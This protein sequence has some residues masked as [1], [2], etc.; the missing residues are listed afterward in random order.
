MK[1]IGRHFELLRSEGTAVRSLSSSD[2]QEGTSSDAALLHLSERLGELLREATASEEVLA[3]A[4]EG[5]NAT[6]TL[7][8]TSD[9]WNERAEIASQCA[10]VAWRHS[11]ALGK[12]K[13]A[14]AWQERFR[15]SFL[16]CQVALESCDGAARSLV[17][18]VGSSFDT[19]GLLC[20]SVWLLGV[21]NE[22]PIESAA[23]TSELLEILRTR[24]WPVLSASERRATVFAFELLEAMAHR[25]G[26]DIAGATELL[27]ALSGDRDHLVQELCARAEFES[28]VVACEAM[29]QASGAD[30]RAEAFLERWEGPQWKREQFKVRLAL[31]Q[32]LANRGRYT[33]A[34]SIMLVAVADP[35]MAGEPVFWLAARHILCDAL[36]RSGATVMALSQLRRAARIARGLGEC[37][38][39]RS[40]EI[41]RA[42][43][44]GSLGR[45]GEA[46][47]IW[48]GAA[49]RFEMC[50]EFGWRG[51]SLF[52][53]GEVLLDLGREGEAEDVLASAVMDLARTGNHAQALAA[54]QLLNELKQNRDSRMLGTSRAR[55]AQR[56]TS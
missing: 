22:R 53:L 48:R 33:L 9:V 14:F 37:G 23:L 1:S 20:I 3:S 51:Y 54:K 32:W 55:G 47:D 24:E 34:R 35:W 52:L 25:I 4:E 12:W 17:T 39:T 31:S 41:Y 38:M 6:R 44:L 19:Y 2:I 49:Q 13:R 43:A 27:A 36:F 16:K 45:L 40:F 10:F 30:R 46:A 29:A 8:G 7:K 15:E 42:D 21:N 50:G 11:L 28:E 26:G 18:T 56:D 5:Y